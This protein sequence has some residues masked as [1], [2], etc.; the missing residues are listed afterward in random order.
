MTTADTS[1][2]RRLVEWS[3]P[4]ASAQDA[5]RL[6]GL[7][8]LQAIVDGELPGPPIAELLRCR[9]IAVTEGSA[10]FTCDLDESM[11]NPIGTIHGGVVCTL[12]DSVLGCAVHSTL[13]AGHGYTSIDTNVQFQR[14][15]RATSGPLTAVGRVTK[16]GR[17]VSFAEGEVADARG[18]VVARGY[19][20]LLIMAP[21]NSPGNGEPR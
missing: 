4:A 6:S 2:R 7:A 14:G 21:E 18:A 17:R 16:A 13:P 19:G 1:P 10:T 15:V 20:T 5:M 11:Y 12:L 8:F 9:M 3:D